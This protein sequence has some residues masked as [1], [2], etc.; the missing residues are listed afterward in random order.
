[1]GE[2]RMDMEK[3]RERTI[4]NKHSSWWLIPESCSFMVS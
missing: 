2:E 1:M 4:G 3:E